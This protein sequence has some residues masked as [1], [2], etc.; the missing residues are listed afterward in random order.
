MNKITKLRTALSGIYRESAA[1]IKHLSIRGKVVQSLYRGAFLPL[2]LAHVLVSEDAV[3][4]YATDEQR[5]A[6]IQVWV[7]MNQARLSAN[8]FPASSD[9]WLDYHGVLLPHDDTDPRI[10][11]ELYRF[12]DGPSRSPRAFVQAFVS[13]IT[14]AV[15]IAEEEAESVTVDIESTDLSDNRVILVNFG[16]KG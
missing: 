5:A 4:D 14:V 7:I 2:S 6:D 1:Y 3:K 15:R 8:G 16:N 9:A 11:R 12:F 13:A 10:L